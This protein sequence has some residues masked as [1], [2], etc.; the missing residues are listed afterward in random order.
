VL[1]AVND[2]EVQPVLE[3]LE[4]VSDGVVRI[5]N[6][7]ELLSCRIDLSL[8]GTIP[9]LRRSEH[10]V[11]SLS[12]LTLLEGADLGANHVLNDRTESHIATITELGRRIDPKIS[13]QRLPSTKSLDGNGDRHHGFSQQAA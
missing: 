6:L 10:P 4:R 3:S 11:E 13:Q 2:H 1:G 7:S 5:H 8:R 9:N 12:L